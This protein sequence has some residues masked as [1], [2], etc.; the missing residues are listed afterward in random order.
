MRAR[1]PGLALAG[2]VCLAGA[3]A[4]AQAEAERR[5][6]AALERLRASLGAEARLSWQRR[7]VDPVT[8][9]ARLLGLAVQTATDRLTVAEARL[10]DLS[11]TRI[12]RAELTGL[13][14]EDG[15]V[16]TAEAARLVV[17]GLPLPPPGAGFDPFAL[18][19]GLLELDRLRVSHAQEGRLALGRLAVSGLRPGALDSAVA[20]ALAFEPEANAGTLGFRLGRLALEAIELPMAGGMPDPAGFRAAAIAIEDAAFSEPREQ[21]EVALA[22]FAMHDW[23]PGRDTRI[24]LERLRVD[25]PFGPLGAGQV[26]LGRVGVSGIDMAGTVAAVLANLQPPDPRPGVPQR[27]AI[28]AVEATLEGRPL[29]GLGLLSADGGLTADGVMTGGFAVEALMLA[30]PPGMDLGLQALGYDRIAGGLSV[31]GQVPRAGGRLSVAPAFVAWD[32]AGRLSVSA[33]LDGIPATAEAGAPV[34]P[35]AAMAEMAAAKLASLVLR[36]DEQGLLERLVAKA[37]RDQGSTPARVREEWARMAEAMPLP[38]APPPG[39]APRGRQPGAAPPDPFAPLRQPVAAFI[40][41]PR[42]IE[43]ALRPPQPIAFAALPKFQSAPP[44]E[45]LRLLGLTV[46]IP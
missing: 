32:G 21:V 24:A 19:L 7:E 10:S 28:E 25:A 39:P 15:K 33:E 30:L 44:A 8:G 26:R 29:L 35:D 1:L 34:D 18:E 12:G 36:W 4:L 41:N 27:M 43:I 2:L 38:G 20:E 5:L 17:A 45:Q 14:M 42:A 9:T 46:R 11:A 6:D 40:R 31:Q 16:A 22:R 3:G 23:I 37:A 13:R